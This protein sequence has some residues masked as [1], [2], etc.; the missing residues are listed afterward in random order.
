MKSIRTAGQPWAKFFIWSAI[1]VYVAGCQKSDSDADGVDPAS[2]CRLKTVTEFGKALRDPEEA[3]EDL[4]EYRYG[5]GNRLESI[6]NT[7]QSGRVYT[8]T[9]EYDA[10]GF[11]MSSKD[12]KTDNRVI[13]TL[14]TSSVSY[15][16][17]SIAKQLYDDGDVYIF[18][19]DTQGKL[20]SYSSEY[21][22]YKQEYGFV[23][24]I[25]TKIEITDNGQKSIATVVDGRA[26][27]LGLTRY[28]YDSKGRLVKEESLNIQGVA[29]GYTTYEYDDFV[30]RNPWF[31]PVQQLKG[32]SSFRNFS[33]TGNQDY[34]VRL[35]RHYNANGTP[36]T[37]SGSAY[38]YLNK[39]NAKGY[40]TERTTF[41]GT[42]PVVD[43]K[44]VSHSRMKYDFIGCN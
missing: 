41:E 33:L 34:P 10:N 22:T 35:K 8:T 15:V 4:Y 25:L 24:G 43:L 29:T 40:L 5:I 28:S 12:T 39:A 14:Y 16:N 11:V 37:G 7:W 18:T 2:Q 1:F 31:L 6:V 9:L 36:K 42:S 3:V 30:A 32:W 27:Q 23:G 21:R 44:T 26:T 13:T 19:Y 20:S 38:V 17:G